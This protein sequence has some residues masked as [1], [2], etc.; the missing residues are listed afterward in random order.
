[1]L[2]RGGARI[3]NVYCSPVPNLHHIAPL[4]VD[5]MVRQAQLH[6]P[7]GV[8]ACKGLR[9]CVCVV[10][11]VC[12]CVW[13]CVCGL[14]MSVYVYVCVGMSTCS[15]DCV[16]VV[17]VCVCLFICGWV[18]VCVCPG[19]TDKVGHSLCICYTQRKV[20]PPQFLPNYF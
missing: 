19:K 16:C 4:H 18:H 14:C 1:M 9:L 3:P 11:Y 20:I 8:C 5:V 10:V 15:C 6:G 17:Y 13:M 7:E 2:I 12:L